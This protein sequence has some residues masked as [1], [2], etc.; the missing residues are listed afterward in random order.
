MLRKLLLPAACTL[1]LGGCVTGYGYG[2]R[3]YYGYDGYAYGQPATRYYGNAGYGYGYYPYSRYG[4]HYGPSIYYGGYYGG[5]PYYGYPYYPYYPRHR[6]D[7][8]DDDRDH[9]RNDRRPP[10][11]ELDG[12]LRE[13]HGSRPLGVPGRTRIARPDQAPPTTARPAIRPPQPAVRPPARTEL[14]TSD[15]PR[16]AAPQMRNRQE[17]D[18]RRDREP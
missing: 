13:L 11:R 8:D 12:G 6:H 5:Y 3:G 18:S 15:R 1:L 2:G 10:W 9:G 7:R 4:Y 14:R 16:P 17:R